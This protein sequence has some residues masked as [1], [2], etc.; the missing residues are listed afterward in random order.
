M[1]SFRKRVL[2]LALGATLMISG[3]SSSV[4]FSA[5]IEVSEAPS[6]PEFVYH[7]THGSTETDTVSEDV[8][9]ENESFDTTAS[10]RT[11]IGADTRTQVTNVNADPFRHYVYIVAEFTDGSI[12]KS[13]GFLIGNKTVVT[14]AHNAYYYDENYNG[15]EASK[16]TVY[17]GG[18]YSQYDISTVGTVHCP[19]NWY[20]S[21][22]T[23][24]HYDYAVLELKNSF[25]IGYMNLD[26]LTDSELSSMKNRGDNL[27]TFGYPH[28]KTSGTLWCSTGTIMSYDSDFIKN[29]VDIVKGNSGGPLVTLADRDTAIGIAITEGDTYNRFL[30]FNSTNLAQIN[31]WRNKYES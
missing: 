2:A 22:G 1:K 30:R 21:Y 6:Y 11:I 5:P 14:A 24:P 15:F 19:Q 8:I 13:T 27:Y 23:D 7:N 9:I 28:D 20:L 26:S 12:G 3:L 17:P 10:P 29:Y 25:D 31:T 18:L 16:I 4:A